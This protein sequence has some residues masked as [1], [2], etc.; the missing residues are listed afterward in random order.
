VRGRVVLVLMDAA[1]KRAAAIPDDL[2][3][4]ISAFTVRS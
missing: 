2:R 4:R 1:T 3:E